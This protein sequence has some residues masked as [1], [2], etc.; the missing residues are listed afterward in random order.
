MV[1]SLASAGATDPVGWRACPRCRASASLRL[2]V[3]AV[4]VSASAR[5][6]VRRAQRS[7]VVRSATRPSARAARARHRPPHQL[8]EHDERDD[9]DDERPVRRSLIIY[10]QSSGGARARA[11][12]R[13][14]SLCV[15]LRK[16]AGGCGRLGT[17]TTRRRRKLLHCF[18]VYDL[19]PDPVGGAIVLLEGRSPCPWRAVG[20]AHRAVALRRSRLPG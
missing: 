10:S 6:A 7:P 8:P 13:H 2:D 14:H 4:I 1:C 17:S 18:G 11:S 19:G 20:A 3:L 5:S 9:L 15:L 12:R 16:A